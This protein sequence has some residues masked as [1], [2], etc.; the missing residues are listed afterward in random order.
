MLVLTAVYVIA[1]IA[2]LGVMTWSNLL[3]RKSIEQA[4]ELELQR[5]R[6][7][8]SLSVKIVLKG[9]LENFSGS[10]Y[11]YLFL[12]NTGLTQANNIQI[13]MS[14]QI[15]AKS[16]ICGENVNII[17]YF[18][19][20]KTPYL[21]PNSNISDDLGFLGN[22][23]EVFEKPIFIGTIT[24]TDLNNKIYKDNFSFDFTTMTTACPYIENENA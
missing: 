24:Y 7:Y 8:L 14:P 9:G 17:P 4:K 11:G 1:T 13:H 5:L 3:T 10:P 20:H 21:A 16:M 15:A 23:F 12:S 18:V 19:E 22:L 2:I 6:P